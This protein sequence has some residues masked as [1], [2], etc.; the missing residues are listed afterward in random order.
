MVCSARL[1]ACNFLRPTPSTSYDLTTTAAALWLLY[2]LLVAVLFSTEKL[3]HNNGYSLFCSVVHYDIMI[4]LHCTYILYHNYIKN[5]LHFSSRPIR[6]QFVPLVV[7]VLLNLI[8]IN[9]YCVGRFEVQQLQSLICWKLF[10]EFNWWFSSWSWVEFSNLL[11][12]R[13]VGM[14]MPTHFWYLWMSS[15]QTL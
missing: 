4:I 6:C 5:V 2:L 14:C 3:S 12:M 15:Y 13:C 11:G 1:L 8:W 7:Q 9:R 10:G